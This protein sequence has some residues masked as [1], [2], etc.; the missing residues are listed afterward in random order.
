MHGFLRKPKRDLIA[1]VPLSVDPGNGT[2]CGQ[3]TSFSFFIIA[4][5]LEANFYADPV[6]INNAVTLYAEIIEPGSG[7]P[8]YQYSEDGGE[9]WFDFT[10]GEPTSMIRTS[11]TVFEIQCRVLDRTGSVSIPLTTLIAIYDPD[12]GFV[13]GGG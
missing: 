2:I 3:V 4:T 8:E 7:G 9:P 11:A 5:P 13:T 10:P 6:P 1:Y 12:G